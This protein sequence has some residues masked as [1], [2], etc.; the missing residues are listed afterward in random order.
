MAETTFTF[1]VEEDLKA[2]FVEAAK[3]RDRTG[4]Q[5]LR[6]FM[7]SLVQRQK[8]AVEHDSWFRDEV[9]RAL[10]EADDPSV[11]RISHEDVLSR[12]HQQR[13]VWAKSW[14]GG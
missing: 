8:Q 2:A 1:R 10:R 7:R 9:E 13:A 12:W 14:G 5:L 3:A 11:N 4:A 6:D